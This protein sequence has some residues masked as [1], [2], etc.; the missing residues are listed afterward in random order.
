MPTLAGLVLIGGFALHTSIKNLLVEQFDHSLLTKVRTLTSFPEQGR[1]GINLAF[2]D[3]PLPEFH[4]GP[5]AEYF[6][7][8]LNDGSVLAKSPSLGA[9]AELQRRTGAGGEPTF[10]SLTLP[11]GRPGRAVGIT[12]E[13][14]KPALQEK[15]SINVTLARDRVQLEK[16]LRR[17][18]FGIILGGTALLALAGYLVRSAAR[19]ALSPV[20][21]LAEEVSA[22]DAASLKSRL[23][24]ASLPSDLKPIAEQINHLMDRLE[25]AFQRERRFASNAAHELLTPVSELRLAAE[26]ALDWPDDPQATSGLATET[27]ELASQMEHTIRSLLAI[28]RAE[29]NLTPLKVTP[30]ELGDLLEELEVSLQSRC[31]ERSLTITRNVVRPLIVT[32]DRVICRAI[33]NNLLLNAAEYATAGSTIRID[34]KRNAEAGVIEIRNAAAGLTAADVEKFCEPFWRG[35]KA[36]SSRDHTGLGLP[37]TKAFVEQLGGSLSFTLEAESIVA[38]HVR[39]PPMEREK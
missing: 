35:D 34:G 21:A 28:S 26:N 11:D 18:A 38:T 13:T 4:G 2:T 5:H 19:G 23:H 8:W 1:M 16:L 12:V 7:V 30:V 33:F 17:L 6:E 39:L 31:Q 20:R 29:A 3:A 22:I 25:A 27:S 15:F 32:T 36:H 14:G 37:L 9:G 10:W 24:A